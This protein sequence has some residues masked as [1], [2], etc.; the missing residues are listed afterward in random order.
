MTT[1]SHSTLHVWTPVA[2]RSRS[3]RCARWLRR[4]RGLPAPP[5]R[6]GLPS[7]PGRGLLLCRRPPP[8]GNENPYTMGSATAARCTTRT[9]ARRG[10]SPGAPGTRDLFRPTETMATVT[11]IGHFIPV[12]VNP[13]ARVRCAVL[14][15]GG[16]P[17]GPLLRVLCMG[18]VKEKRRLS[19]TPAL[20]WGKAGGRCCSPTH[21]GGSVHLPSS[22][23]ISSDPRL[24]KRSSHSTRT[25]SPWRY[26]VACV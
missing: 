3:A 13:G 1:A 12:V 6:A 19:D 21:W 17:T 15:D 23:R 9:N 11:H 25:A 5:D 24:S 22:Q 26:V 20:P 7:L 8:E 18:T 10:R 14:D 16:L 2:S 4:C